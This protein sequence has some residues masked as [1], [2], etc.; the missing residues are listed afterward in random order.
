ML[1]TL[2]KSKIHRAHITE[3][4]LYYEGSVT[5]DEELMQAANIIEGE[6][7]EVFNLN[8]GHRLETYAIKGKAGSGVVCLNGPASRGACVGDEVVIV[9][10]ALAE[11]QEIKNI[12][13]RIIKVDVR[14]QIKD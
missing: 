8:N 12:K 7:V 13:P 4:N 9:S 1:R 11:E 3:A 14:N 5:I 10:Y 6:K 2:L